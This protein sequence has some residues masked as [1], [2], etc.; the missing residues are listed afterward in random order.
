MKIKNL[1]TVDG[2]FNS[3][4]QYVSERSFRT[5]IAE[6]VDDNIDHGCYYFAFLTYQKLAVD[7]TRTILN[8]IEIPNLLTFMT[9]A[10]VTPIKKIMLDEDTLEKYEYYIT[11]SYEARSKIIQ[12]GLPTEP[13]LG[14]IDNQKK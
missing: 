3:S 9:K 6:C 2:L 14:Q 11:E 7:K 5:I 4:G 12:E 8:F 1:Y 10:H 13:S